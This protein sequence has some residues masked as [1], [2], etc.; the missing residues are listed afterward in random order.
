[1]V[2]IIISL[3]SRVLSVEDEGVY[4][5]THSPELILAGGGIDITR[6]HRGK[7][8]RWSNDRDP[9]AEKSFQNNDTL[10]Q[11]DGTTWRIIS[12][13]DSFQAIIC[14]CECH[15]NSVRLAALQVSRISACNRIVT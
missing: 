7:N 3:A 15:R 11:L 10:A 12:S 5:S 8:F 13:S 1:M 6:R 14:P 2:E 9:Y 4:W